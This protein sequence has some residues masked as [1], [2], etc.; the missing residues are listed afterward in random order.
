MNLRPDQY[1]ETPIGLGIVESTW[2]WISQPRH[3]ALV[4][5]RITS[6]N[7]IH[8]DDDNCIT[9]QAQIFGLWIYDADQLLPVVNV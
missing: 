9:R 6:A 1:V 3:R 2:T 5:V 7:R 8:L 4:R